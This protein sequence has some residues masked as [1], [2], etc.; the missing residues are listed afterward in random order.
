MHKFPLRFILLKVK[1]WSLLCLGVKRNALKNDFNWHACAC[2]S[3]ARMIWP[4]DIFMVYFFF[5]LLIKSSKRIS[6]ET[7]EKR[8]L[9]LE[10][11]KFKGDTSKEREE[12]ALQSREILQ[13]FVTGGHE[14]APHHTNICK[15]SRLWGAISSLVFNKSFSNL[16]TLL[17][18]RGS[19]Q[20][21][22]RIFA[23]WP[24]HFKLK[25]PW[26]VVL[27]GC[28]IFFTHHR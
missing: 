7:A 21:C 3:C 2:A 25:K 19:F 6:I 5:Q 17:I 27:W 22:W 15:I 10:I 18:L 12:I 16:A 26:K 28:L 23:K 9:K 11:T 8:S 4:I 1:R 13:T 14:L 20:S 24:S